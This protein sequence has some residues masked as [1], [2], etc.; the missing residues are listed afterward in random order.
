[1]TDFKVSPDALSSSATAMTG[2]GESVDGI[3][4]GMTPPNPLMCGMLIGP[5]VSIFA[6][7]VHMG[8][9]A[10]VKG[11]AHEDKMLGRNLELTAEAYRDVE[12]EATSACEEFFGGI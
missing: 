7:I 8:A 6:Q 9:Q 1:M 4:G 10:V 2:V 3:A 11:V 5:V 12:D